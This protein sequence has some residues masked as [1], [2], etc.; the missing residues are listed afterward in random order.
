MNTQPVYTMK[1]IVQDVSKILHNQS[2]NLSTCLKVYR[3]QHLYGVL[4][5]QT[6]TRLD[7]LS[8]YEIGVD[9]VAKLICM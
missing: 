8:E 6:K 4:I 1:M 7:F 3:V 2:A 9:N 5:Y